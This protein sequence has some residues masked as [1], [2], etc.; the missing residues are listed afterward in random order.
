MA[1]GYAMTRIELE[2][3]RELPDSDETLADEKQWPFAAMLGRLGNAADR[4]ALLVALVPG[5]SKGRI[6]RY[7]LRRSLK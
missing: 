6:G 4:H 1:A 2:R 3:I 7:R 5:K